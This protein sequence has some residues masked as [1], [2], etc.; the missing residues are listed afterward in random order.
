MGAMRLLLLICVAVPSVVAWAV[1]VGGCAREERFEFTRVCMGVQT[2][3]L[4]YGRTRHAAESAAASA[5]SRIGEL[6]AALSD[7]RPASDLSHVNA[8]AGGTVGVS[9]D[10]ADVMRE[11]LELARATNGAFNPALGPAVRQW[12]RMRDRGE[13]AT[14]DEIAQALALCDWREVHVSEP[15]LVP[16]IRL[17]R[18]G[19][20]LDLGAV[21]KGYAAEEAARRLIEL[22]HPRCL[23]ALAGD[24]YAG[25]PPPGKPGWQVALMSDRDTPSPSLTSQTLFVRNAAVSTSGD[26]EQFVEIDGQRY[27]HII[28]PETGLGAQTRHTATV[29]APRG[30]HAD[31]LATA[32]F[33]WQLGKTGGKEQR[34]VETRPNTRVSHRS[35]NLEGVLNRFGAT[36]ILD[37][38]GQ[39]RRVFNPGPAMGD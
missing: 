5:F 24:I 37:E 26:F 31:A 38:P 11:S 7:Y 4:L 21:A 18:A 8:G 27:A 32:A 10:L 33:V 16:T 6:D 39:P 17:G 20:M 19:M 34:E 25:D 22:G 29:I 15:G 12:R 14:P 13:R 2:R 3:V 30:A 9:G 35:F 1:L 36:A 28:D 23:V